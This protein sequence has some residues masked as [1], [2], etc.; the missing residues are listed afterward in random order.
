MTRALKIARVVVSATVFVLL[1]A[2]LSCAMWFIP[3][4]ES[5]LCGVQLGPA[6]LGMSLTVIALWL[7]ITLVFGRIYCSTVCP[8]GTLMDVSAR[9]KNLTSKGRK[10][11][12]HYENPN[13]SFR[14]LFLL[15]AILGAL[16]GFIILPS[17]LDPFNAFCRIC[18]GVFNPVLGFISG[19]LAEIGVNSQYVAMAVTSSVASSIIAL[20]LFVVVFVGSMLFGRAICNIMCPVGTILGMV[21]RYSIFQFDIDTDLCTQCRSCEQ[22]CKSCCID[23]KDHVVDGSRCVV[24]FNCINVCPN[25]AIRYTASRKRLA[26]PLMQRIKNLEQQAEPSLDSVDTISKKLK[27]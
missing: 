5:L 14:L 13:T 20:A 21:S 16:D 7:L 23:M 8:M 4:V 11:K 27:K 15:T 24:C 6:V 25:R 1:V 17:V 10:R 9:A 3:G 26:T 22:V 18:A 2:G 12:Y 19:G